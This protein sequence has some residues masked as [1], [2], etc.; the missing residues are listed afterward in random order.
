MSQSQKPQPPPR[1][2]PSLE[3][4]DDID[5]L[6]SAKTPPPLNPDG[7][8]NMES[9]IPVTNTIRDLIMKTGGSADGDERDIKF[10]EIVAVGSQVSYFK[11]N[12]SL[13]V[14][15]AKLENNF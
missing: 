6:K 12:I 2:A 10:P 5:D 8:E 1:R 4:L 11:N 15:D 14:F 13:Q 7:V 9:L 3:S